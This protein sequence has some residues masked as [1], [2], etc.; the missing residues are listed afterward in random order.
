[1][2]VGSVQDLCGCAAA[3][4]A[5]NAPRCVPAFPPTARL[6]ELN[7]E[8]CASEDITSQVEKLTKEVVSCFEVDTPRLLLSSGRDHAA[9]ASHSLSLS[10]SL[11]IATAATRRPRS[12]RAS[13]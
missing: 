11:A 9:S 2:V 13:C 5:T 7:Q 4:V 3:A 6:V 10:L 12:P 8:T 1:M